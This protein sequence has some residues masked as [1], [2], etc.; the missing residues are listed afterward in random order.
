MTP[1]PAPASS[2]SPAPSG[3]LSST[4]KPVTASQAPPS[5]SSSST[6]AKPS[7]SPS[8]QPSSSTSASPALLIT[9]TITD[10]PQTTLS[11][12]LSVN[13]TVSGHTILS[14]PPVVTSYSTT[15]TAGVYVTITHIAANPTNALAGTQSKESTSGFYSNH[16]AVAGVFTAVGLAIA[17]FLV[18]LFLLI[19]RRNHTRDRKQLHSMISHTTGRPADNYGDQASPPLMRTVS[20][21][22]RDITWGGSARRHLLDDEV[23]PS[24]S[25]RRGEFAG[26]Y[27][28]VGARGEFTS[29]YAGI[30]AG[31]TP[32]QHPLYEGPFSDY[33]S[34]YHPSFPVANGRDSSDDP[35]QSKASLTPSSPSIYPN[36][37]PP[38]VD[39]NFYARQEIQTHARAQGTGSL[40]ARP[41]KS[42][43]RY[44]SSNNP[45]VPSA[46]SQSRAGP[47]I[48]RVHVDYQFK[49]RPEADLNRRRTLLDVRPR[50][51]DSMQSRP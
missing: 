25:P 40:P 9:S 49:G 31:G 8:P 51:K 43:A 15:L 26:S 2:T 35:N 7:P 13:V 20:V 27:A 17:A 30:G 18:L 48:P 45:F 47:E 24:P 41:P 38:A 5:S 23:A 6:S 42:E 3:S 32:G 36:S 21:D 28:G 10:F 37:L 34:P 19:R 39:E 14:A 50:S 1:S 12:A 33:H 22:R 11:K 4:Q 16:G 46:P 29:S 44:R